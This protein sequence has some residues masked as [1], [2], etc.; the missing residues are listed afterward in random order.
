MGEFQCSIERKTTYSF[1]MGNIK[2][3]I[4]GKLWPEVISVKGKIPNWCKV[5]QL[6]LLIEVHC[7]KVVGLYYI[8]ARKWYFCCFCVCVCVHKLYFEVLSF[9]MSFD[10]LAFWPQPAARGEHHRWKRKGREGK[11]CD[12]SCEPQLVTLQE[13]ELCPN[14][15]SVLVI[16]NLSENFPSAK[17]NRLGIRGIFELV[18][19]YC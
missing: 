12:P 15:I 10:A 7:S 16:L 9:K 3:R 18:L 11:G 6:R 14:F 4:Q 19:Y 5:M 1:P 17:Q 8:L 2:C 13:K